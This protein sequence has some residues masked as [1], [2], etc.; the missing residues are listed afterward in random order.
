MRVRLLVDLSFLLYPRRGSF[1]DAL[2][3]CCVS[4]H[5]CIS[6]SCI[7]RTLT[8]RSLSFLFEPTFVALVDLYRIYIHP[9]FT[10]THSLA[11]TVSLPTQR[12]SFGASG[13]TLLLERFETKRVSKEGASQGVCPV[14]GYHR[15]ISCQ[16][17]DFWGCSD[18]FRKIHAISIVTPI[19]APA[20][21]R[22][23]FLF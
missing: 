11:K 20:K 21:E 5:F 19:G 4:N 7:L 22:G 14:T 17:S 1:L 6:C 12:N 23:V 15:T 13:T 2:P 8:N 9:T 16:E 18:K 3:T 10:H